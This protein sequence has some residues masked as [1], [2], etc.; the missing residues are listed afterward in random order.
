MNKEL[1]RAKER[2]ETKTYIE[3]RL[4][5]YE[6]L[7]N[8]DNAGYIHEAV[9]IS[10]QD[11]LEE[12]LKKLQTLKALRKRVHM[13]RGWSEWL[14]PEYDPYDH[15]YPHESVLNELEQQLVKECNNATKAI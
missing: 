12:K 4:P 3:N 7:F 2:I 9:S 6:K 14:E 15:M 1:L 10:K 13:Q 8:T 11:T 5:I